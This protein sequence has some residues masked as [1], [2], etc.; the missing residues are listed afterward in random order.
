M[1]NLS[2]YTAPP[3][4]V[5]ICLLRGVN[6]GG[7]NKVKMDALRSVCESLELQ[8]PR[9]YVQSGNIVF[10][11]KEKDLTRLAE[12]IGNEI[13]RKF[14]FRPEVILRTAS[15]LRSVIARNPFSNRRDIE[16]GK[17]L[18]SFLAADPGAEARQ[19]LL[20]IKADPEEIH[21]DARELY[22]YFP[23][24]QGK[25][26]LSFSLIDRTLKIPGTGRNWNTVTKLLETAEKLEKN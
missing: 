17:L 3:M 24:G 21:I 2:R 20:N 19:Q 12:R 16:P 11:T 25:T 14:K 7:H 15:D 10:K 18:V 1:G 5:V 13:H 9:T 26:K 8:N 4:P 6:V 23:N 22:I